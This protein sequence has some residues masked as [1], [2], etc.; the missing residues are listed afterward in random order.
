MDSESLLVCCKSTRNFFKEHE[1]VKVVSS[2]PQIDILDM[3]GSENSVIAVGG[4][5]VIDTA[6]ILSKNPIICFPTT[7]SGSSATSWSVYWD[8]RNKKSLKRMLPKEVNFESKFV[9]NLSNEVLASTTC[10]V[11]SHCI[12]SLVSK[13]ATTESK[14][15]C[16]EVLDMLDNQKGTI[17]LIKA[18]HIA[19]K[20][21]EITGTNLL[22]SLSYPVTAHYG[23][24]HGLA[25]GYFLPK[26]SRFLGF[27][28]DHLIKDFNMHLEIDLDFV[29]N[30]AF[31]YEKINEC[32][33]KLNKIIIKELY[34]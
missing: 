14:D 11:I 28:I 2:A 27:D 9:Q 24:P 31:K 19:G 15:Y 21:I 7:A 4:G 17:D 1:K 23:T 30:E 34:K 33:V 32:K 25:L 16:N 22:H 6:K 29:I 18:G 20:A 12:D 8:H 10:D 3:I 5:A 13:K 26:I